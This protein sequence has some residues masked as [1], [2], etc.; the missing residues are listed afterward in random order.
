MLRSSDEHHEPVSNAPRGSELVKTTTSSG[1][2]NLV[3]LRLEV[4]MIAYKHKS[5]KCA[6]DKSMSTTERR[7]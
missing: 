6:I 4:H 7:E 1:A 5:K 3:V 2:T